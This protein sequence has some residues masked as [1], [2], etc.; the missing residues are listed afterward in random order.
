MELLL[1]LAAGFTRFFSS[2]PDRVMN[3]YAEQHRPRDYDEY[4][5]IYLQPHVYV[6]ADSKQMFFR[7]QT[8][9]IIIVPGKMTTYTVYPDVRD[10]G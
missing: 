5:L 3:S 9:S 7:G 4:K 2:E 8:R 6:Y 10:S 1:V